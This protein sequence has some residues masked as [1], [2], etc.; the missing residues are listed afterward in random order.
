VRKDQTFD[1]P[2]SLKAQMT[3]DCERARELLATA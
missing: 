2:E 3:A 1:N